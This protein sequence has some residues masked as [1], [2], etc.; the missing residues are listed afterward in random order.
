MEIHIG[1]YLQQLRQARRVSLSRLAERAQLAKGTLSYW[2]AGRFQ[3]RMPELEALLTAIEATPAQ[4]EQA[5]ALINAP[6]AARSLRGA[7]RGL[8][9][10]GDGQQSD[11]GAM[12]AIGDLLRALRRRRGWTPEQV[13]RALR[14]HSST[15]RRW[16]N[17]Q[18]VVPAE[19]LDDLC[20][21]LRAAPGERG[22]LA[23]RRLH[24]GPASANGDTRVTPEA[25]WEQCEQMR[26]QAENGSTGLIDLRLLTLEAQ[27]WP[28][29]ARGGQHGPARRALARVFCTHAWYLEVSGRG[30]EVAAYAN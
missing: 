24:L 17:S 1:V 15:V 28:Q 12:P 23:A 16:E 9:S 8:T 20:Q 3:P 19:R 5:L 21:A 22:A 6:R 25:A 27:L 26:A 14:V 13:A 29:A 30:H 11:L 4:R 2:E 10:G 18:V 7:Q